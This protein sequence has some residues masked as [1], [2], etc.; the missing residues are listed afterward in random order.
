LRGAHDPVRSAAT[1]FL[2]LHAA[3][4]LEKQVGTAVASK[5]TLVVA[6][7]A[8]FWFCYGVG[9][10]DDERTA[11]FDSA[12]RQLSR[13]DAPLIIGDLPDARNAVGGVLDKTQMP[14]LAA[15]ARCN[16]RLQ[17]WAAE[18]KRVV[19]FPLSRVMAAA[20]A[21][22]ELVLA[23]QRWE[24]GK[25]RRLVQ[26]DQL[27]PSRHALA[28]LAIEALEMAAAG[29]TPPAPLTSLCR[30]LE[31]VYK[32]ALFRAKAETEAESGNGSNQ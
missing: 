8:L 17:A 15:I 10:S 18:R 23:G 6:L 30:D 28:A 25:S 31:T 26:S 29:F 16:Q 14:G 5:P 20:S 13:I 2:F 1:T 9:V 22:E 4:S 7:D 19:I 27:H 21:N 32:D 24:K 11:R 3:E 12:L